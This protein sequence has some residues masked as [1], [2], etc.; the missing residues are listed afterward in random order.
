MQGVVVEGRLRQFI[1]E[2]CDGRG[3]LQLLLFLGRHPLAR[4]SHL[5]IVHA[6]DAQKADIDEAIQH[7]TD[8]GVVVTQIAENGLYFYS[9]T[10][11]E[12]LRDRV[13][14]LVTLDWWQF[15]LMLEQIRPTV[16]A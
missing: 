8:K 7:L 5:A 6:L 4:F 3:S 1:G 10:E 9:L 2:Y 14:E 15:Q 16:E 11:D 13:S 12:S